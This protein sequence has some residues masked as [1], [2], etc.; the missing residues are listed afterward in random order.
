MPKLEILRSSMSKYGVAIVSKSV[1]QKR[2]IPAFW[3]KEE[4]VNESDNGWRIYG[5]NDPEDINLDPDNFVLVPFKKV[6]DL[7]DLF[8]QIFWA[9]T[10]T[11]LV[12]E[13]TDNKYSDIYCINQEEYIDPHPTWA[14]KAI[15]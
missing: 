13:F 10:G 3:F 6:N 4:P 7:C 14:L 9:P 5:L 1:Y 15:K 8:A 12:V 2:D 11:D